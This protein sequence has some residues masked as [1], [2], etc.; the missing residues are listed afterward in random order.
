[1]NELSFPDGFRW[2]AA[3]ASYQIE[4]GVI[5]GGRGP[6]IWDTFGAVE[7]NVLDGATGDVACDHYHR[8]AGDIALVAELGLDAYRFSVAWPRVMP[9]GRTTSA[10]GLAFYDRLVDE[11]LR[12]DIEP[13]LTLYHWDLPQAIEDAGGWPE[14]DTAARFADYA[15]V[16]HDALGDRVTQWTTINEPFCAAFLGYGSGVHAP[17]IRDYDTSLIAAHHLLLAHGLAMKALT[18]QA[19]PGQEFSLALN[20]APAIADGD[21]PAHLEAA[22]KWDAIHNRFFLDPVLGKGYPSD[23]MAAVE[24]HGGRFAKSI[25]DGDLETIAAPVAWLGVNYYAPT[26]VTPLDDPLKVSNCPLPGLRGLDVL[27]AQAPLTA[28]GWEQTPSS[29]A[30]LLTWLNERTGGLPLVVAEN[31]AS[32]VDKVDPDGRVR[33]ADRIGYYRGHLA[34]VHDAIAAG[35]DVRGY[36]AWSLLDNFE[37]A[38][39]YSQ[40][41][42]IIHVDFATQQRRIKDSGYFLGEVAKSNSL[43]L[44]DS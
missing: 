36:F 33:D 37:W 14:R 13:V 43:N 5:E 40:R 27:P 4:G 12:Q 18:G 15:A 35:A 31:G 21:T 3:T 22:R 28:F 32:F 38:M 10:A 17:G 11:L 42:G 44:E 19:R 23:A 1:M 26:R 6:S 25:M 7:G 9:D 39:G 34:A 41:F 30:G 24:H 16:V 8:Y 20:F 2:G 29:L